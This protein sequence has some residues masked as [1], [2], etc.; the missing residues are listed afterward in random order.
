MS[1]ATLASP[2][3]DAAD[4]AELIDSVPPVEPDPISSPADEPA[5]GP[6]S[7]PR[8]SKRPTTRSARAAASAARQANPAATPPK[9]RAP[10]AARPTSTKTQ[11]AQAAQGLH[12]LA[13]AL[14]LPM[15]GMP[16]TGVA[17]VAAAPDAGKLWAELSVRYPAIARV[18]TGGSDGLLFAQLAMLYFP[19][20]TAGLSERSSPSSGPAMDPA[21]FLAG[22]TDTSA[23][24]G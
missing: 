14:V 21:A 4:A 18:F 11:V 12:E 13:G 2:F 1:A 22:L 9:D 8:R 6:D 19:L 17:L 24:G 20:I 7:K 16:H 5:A 23:S 3:L 15:A 10:K